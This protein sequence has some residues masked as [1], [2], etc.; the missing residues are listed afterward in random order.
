MR[1]LRG[2]ALALAL[3]VL[4]TCAQDATPP[5]QS[6]PTLDDGWTT[7]S[8]E[9]LGVD[10][11]RLA[12][13]TE[14]IRGWPELG[15]HA[16]LIERSDRLIYEEY[17]DGFDERLGQPLGHVSFTRDS[18]HDLR[19]VSK[20]VVS[21]LVGIAIATGAIQSLD[22]PVIE[23]F[24]EYPEPDTNEQRRMTLSH[25]LSMT[26]GLAWNENLPYSDPSNDAIRMT[27][28]PQPLRYVL[29]RPFSVDP[30]SGFNYNSG[31]SEVVAAVLER[32]TKSSL[33][34]YARTRLFRPL[35]IS[36]FEWVGN[37]AGKP[38]AAS[39]LRLRARDVAK[40]ASLYLHGGQWNG[41]QVIPAD[42]VALSTR[43]HFRFPP[44]EGADAGGEF[45]YS[46]YWWYFCYPTT[47]GLMEARTAFGNGQQWIFVLPGLDM[48]VTILGGRYNDF[49]A[50][51]TLGP[52]ILR[53]HVIPA[54][55]TAVRPGCPN[56]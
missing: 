31:L 55:R 10:A 20:S 13:L 40:F 34:D 32:A 22:G 30:G 38:E 21:A 17:F 56:A 19:S 42:W 53:E 45:G 33:E 27:H 46:Y 54:V 49:T 37:L 41:N 9:S 51:A 39:G 3:F 25:A 6:P 2:A 50:A 12:S 8:A 11:G 43:R 26:S 28:D 52:R 36:D 35:G 47:A 7:A 15:V 14:S 48:A 4:T 24:P 16:I 23:W 29:S 44:P 1:T 5:D 18:M